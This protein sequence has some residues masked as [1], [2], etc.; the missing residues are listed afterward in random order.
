MAPRLN[1]LPFFDVAYFQ[2]VC[3]SARSSR[4]LFFSRRHDT[5]GE[6]L[7]TTMFRGLT[8]LRE[9]IIERSPFVHSDNVREV[10]KC[11][12]AANLEFRLVTTR[13]KFLKTSNCKQ[14]EWLNV[15]GRLDMYE[16]K[17][18]QSQKYLFAIIRSAPPVKLSLRNVY[19]NYSYFSGKNRMLFKRQLHTSF[20][21]YI[22]LKDGK[23][24]IS[25]TVKK[26]FWKEAFQFS[27]SRSRW[28]E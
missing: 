26:A 3:V 10:A 18:C 22:V 1:L 25:E 19:H 15:V 4:A 7:P 2:G 11:T 27:E 6:I 23:E 24:H 9:K 21:H 20:P 16:E 14:P 5:G 8:R 17:R 28:A 13:S 12:T